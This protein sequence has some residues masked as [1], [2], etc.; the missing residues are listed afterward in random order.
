MG[1]DWVRL[2]WAGGAWYWVGQLCT[3]GPTHRLEEPFPRGEGRL[4]PL[5]T[6]LLLAG[7]PDARKVH[8]Q[9][10]GLPSAVQRELLARKPGGRD[11]RPSATM[12]VLLWL[13]RQ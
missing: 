12:R 1:W 4:G 7:Q 6:A 8:E 2:C 9:Q 3:M 5:L 13:S 10:A 11:P